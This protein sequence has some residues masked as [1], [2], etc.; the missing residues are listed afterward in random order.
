MKDAENQDM[1]IFDN[2]SDDVGANKV[3]SNRRDEFSALAG[4]QRMRGDELEGLDQRRMVARRLRLA[5]LTDP[6][7]KDIDHIVVGTLRKAISHQRSTMPARRR[8]S[9]NSSSGVRLL[10][11]LSIPSVINR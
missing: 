5:E 2:L 7:A 11:P 3:H 10:M 1:I 6:V 9:R 8:A 4:G